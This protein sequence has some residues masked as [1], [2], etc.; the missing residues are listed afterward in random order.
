MIII[1]LGYY[2]LSTSNHLDGSGLNPHTGIIFASGLVLGPYGAFGASL[3]NVI[4]T[5]FRGQPISLSLLSGF[6]NF[7]I[8]CLCYKLWYSKL[9]NEEIYP[10]RLV[11]SSGLIKFLV[12]LNITG[13]I[14]SLLKPESILIFKP[15]SA[16]Y[17]NSKFFFNYVNFGAIFGIIGIWAARAKNYICLPKISR[18]RHEYFYKILFISILVLTAIFI[19]NDFML[20]QESGNIIIEFSLITILLWIFMTKPLSH[21]I[22]IPENTTTERIMDMFLLMSMLIIIGSLI[23][24]HAGGAT[25]RSYTG[26]TISYDEVVWTYLLFSDL[27]L[28]VFVIPAGIILRYVD[29][30]LSKPILTFSKIENYIQKGKKIETEGLLELYSQYNGEKTEIGKLARSYSNLITYNNHY[31]E[32]INKI[33]SERERMK[34]ELNI[35]ERIQQSNLPTEAIKNEF[36]NV[37]GYSKPAKEVGGDFFDYFEID[38][39]NLAIIIGDAS[40]K[41][42]PAAL[43]TTTTQ[44]LIKE[45]LNHEKDPSKILYLVNNHIC[46]HNS[47]TMFITLFL[48]IYNKNT[49]TLT[50]SNAGHNP[51]LIKKDNKFELMDLDTGLVI[52]I[53]ENYE[54]ITQEI[55]L[56]S[57]IILYTDGI[58]EAINK[59][60][61]MYGEERLIDFFNKNPTDDSIISKLIEN[62]SIFTL[63][64]EQFDDMTIL[65]LK[66]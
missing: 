36:Y 21:K 41:G 32:N 1:E 15:I 18:P 22:S 50:F 44:T 12:I 28:V 31:I 66:K 24:T 19:I 35:A 52:G 38:D 58:T 63:G 9:Y 16:S 33:E 37:S 57:E 11:N 3:G 48:G 20:F 65:I 27:F 62:I 39:E 23:Y 61:E 34:A 51:P 17:M 46:W 55:E 25:I 5:L 42:V 13:A 26:E 4:Y 30:R 49:N 56:G 29:N 59:D 6:V 47:E 14:Y 8:S 43:L 45:L 10:P 40:G 60:E 54:F 53:L 7:T 2:I 64:E